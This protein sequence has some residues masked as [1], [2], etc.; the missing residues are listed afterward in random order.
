MAA[1]KILDVFIEWNPNSEED[2]RRE[3][4]RWYGPN[5]ELELVLPEGIPSE[6]I[7]ACKVYYFDPFTGEKT[8]AQGTKTFSHSAGD[9]LPVGD[10]NEISV[11]FTTTANSQAGLSSY[12]DPDGDP[13]YDID[14]GVEGKLF[15]KVVRVAS[16]LEDK[17]DWTI[18][19]TE[20]DYGE[21][22][23]PDFQAA[24]ARYLH[25]EEDEN[26]SFEELYVSTSP[27]PNAVVKGDYEYSFNI[28]DVLDAGTHILTV[29]FT[30]SNQPFE[31]KYNDSISPVTKEISV[32]VNPIPPVIQWDT[33]QKSGAGS[34]GE[35]FISPCEV[36]SEETP[37]ITN[38]QA[39]Y[40]VEALSPVEGSVGQGDPVPGSWV[41]SPPAGTEIYKSTDISAVFTPSDP[42]YSVVSESFSF[43][44][45]EKTETDLT[46]PTLFNGLVVSVDCNVGFGGDTSNCSF[47]VVDDP[48][49]GF[50]TDIPTAGTACY[51]RYKDFF[52]GGILQRWNYSESISG[53]KYNI[54]LSSPSA[55]MD[56]VHIILDAFEGTAY[57]GDTQ[58]EPWTGAQVPY[59]QGLVRN[60]LNPLGYFENYTLGLLSG[61]DPD[62]T[63]LVDDTL[64][65]D[66]GFGTW[67]DSG[68]NPQGFDAIKLL[69]TIE[70]IS[71]G[72]TPHGDKLFFGESQ[73]SLDLSELIEVVPEY[74]RVSGSPNIDLNSL[75]SDVC[76]LTQRDYIWEVTGETNEECDD[77]GEPF[78]DQDNVVLKVKLIDKSSPPDPGVIAQYVE[79]ARE[80]GT[81]VNSSVGKEFQ[82]EPTQKIVLGGPASRYFLATAADLIP[83]FAQTN[84]GAYVLARDFET[85][86]DGAYD[87]DR[88]VT[89]YV[90][91][92]YTSPFSGGGNRSYTATIM[93]LRQARM[94]YD[95]WVSFKFVE[96]VWKNTLGLLDPNSGAYEGFSV[97]ADGNFGGFAAALGFAKPAGPLGG[98]PA[99]VILNNI[100]NV[101][102][103]SA[104]GP[105]ALNRAELAG[106]FERFL[107]YIEV[108]NIET[109]ESSPVWQAVSEC[110]TN[111]YGRKFLV[112]LPEEPG[113]IE[114][115]LKVFKEDIAQVPSWGL[116]DS[117]WVEDAPLSNVKF[118]DSTGRLKPLNVYQLGSYNQGAVG[119]TLNTTAIQGVAYQGPSFQQG[120][121]WI[122]WPGSVDYSP[123]VLA[124][125]EMQV[126]TTDLFHSKDHGFLNMLLYMNE[127]FDGTDLAR[128]NPAFRE[129]LGMTT[130]DSNGKTEINWRPYGFGPAI[131]PPL[132]IGIPQE[133]KRYSWGPWYNS[134]HLNG[135]LDFVFDSQ[136]VPESFGSIDTMAETAQAQAD[137]GIATMEE[138]ENGSIEIA[139]FPEYNIGDRLIAT[140]PYV[141]SI[142]IKIGVGGMT[143][144]YR[145]NTWTPDFGKLQ[146]YNQSR[147]ARIWRNK[148]NAAQ[149]GGG[150]V[151]GAKDSTVKAQEKILDNPVNKSAFN[152]HV[153]IIAGNAGYEP[154]TQSAGEISPIVGSASIVD[155]FIPAENRPNNHQEVT[156]VITESISDVVFTDPAGVGPRYS[157][158]FGMSKEQT[159]VGFSSNRERN[160]HDV[161]PSIQDPDIDEEIVAGEG[162]ENSPGTFNYYRNTQG[163]SADNNGS[164]M[165]TSN[166]LDPYFNYAVFT[167]NDTFNVVGSDG[168]E[169]TNPANL[170]IKAMSDD[171]QIVVHDKN[172]LPP[173]TMNLKTGL[174]LEEYATNASNNYTTDQT[175]DSLSEFRP[176]GL[177]G[178]MVLS[179]WGFDVAN[180]PVPGTVEDIRLFNNNLAYNRNLWKTGPVNLMW[181]KERKIW[182]GGLETLTGIV[183]TDVESPESPMNPTTFN[184]KV[185]R[186]VSDQKG[187]GAL[188]HND[189]PEIIKCYNRDP[190]FSMNAGENSYLTVMRINYEWVPLS[191]GGGVDLVGFETQDPDDICTTDTQVWWLAISRHSNANS[192]TITDPTEFPMQT[193]NNYYDWGGFQPRKPD[194]HLDYCQN[195]GETDGTQVW[196]NHTD[197]IYHGSSKDN[198]ATNP[199]EGMNME[200]WIMKT[201]Y[202]RPGNACMK[203]RAIAAS[204]INVN[205]DPSYTGDFFGIRDSYTNETGDPTDPLDSELDDTLAHYFFFVKDWVGDLSDDDQ[206]NDFP[207]GPELSEYPT[208]GRY[209]Y[210]DSAFPAV[211]VY[212][213]DDMTASDVA[214]AIMDAWRDS[215]F[216]ESFSM[217]QD[218]EVITICQTRDGLTGDQNN[219][220][221]AR[222]ALQPITSTH[223]NPDLENGRPHEGNFSEGE[224]FDATTWLADNSSHIIDWINLSENGTYF[225]NGAP[226]D[227]WVAGGGAWTG[228]TDAPVS[229][230]GTI[231]E[232]GINKEYGYPNSLRKDDWLDMI[233]ILN[234]MSGYLGNHNF[235]IESFT[236]LT[237]A[238]DPDTNLPYLSDCNEVDRRCITLESRPEIEEII[239]RIT[240]YP[241][242][243]TSVPDEISVTPDP[244]RGA[245]EVDPT[246]NAGGYIKI[247]DP[248]EGF[249]GGEYPRRFESDLRGRK[250]VAMRVWDYLPNGPCHDDPDYDGAGVV[251]EDITIKDVV[252]AS[253]Q[254]VITVEGLLPTRASGVNAQIKQGDLT[255]DI[256][257]VDRSTNSVTI[258]LGGQ[259]LPELGA[260]QLCSG[261][262]PECYWMVVYMDMFDTIELVHD[263]IIGT[264]TITTQKKKVDVWNHCDLD[265]D[266]YEGE[267]CVFDDED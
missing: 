250:G 79:D 81:L 114:N 38:S 123:F 239:G 187:D 44:V 80:A 143:T 63:W 100:A 66:W 185:L 23:G 92:L 208:Y 220:G 88:E 251:C 96:F 101:F 84:S 40:P 233:D 132:A 12:L 1:P 264:R 50:I 122:D 16:S 263:I 95:A 238:I 201:C 112:K 14:S 184:L 214:Q 51:F 215:P 41:Y 6:Y 241:C 265:D 235:T 178:P 87:S 166:D 85:V 48:E 74:Y 46:V 91:S 39:E 174:D 231:Y 173:E 69:K 179:G 164:I 118:Y 246:S 64:I 15:I 110:A 57:Y 126:E 165:P 182:S 2:L 204:E 245:W 22:L 107:G 175:V 146:K 140:G 190:K 163:D 147:V 228:P 152:P 149:K 230:T 167:D 144:S 183:V 3:H 131:V 27:A 224:G 218:C 128:A 5:Q 98:L 52:F 45:P 54:T 210:L 153:A 186:K 188:A 222:G 240:Q 47:V 180:N 26:T 255:Y 161:L 171:F 229:G 73:Y 134:N 97:G 252:R 11:T 77:I 35:R 217:T 242:G 197:V 142:S 106:M 141:T 150:S 62:D 129:L 17:V 256:V 70:V 249:F 104:R 90:K 86:A 117:A 53:K 158:N 227:A 176:A 56:G 29:T 145:F 78:V 223:P 139:E 7:D 89:L 93:E 262:E 247:K 32:T 82:N 75:V 267:D 37:Y 76:E 127:T 154:Y 221:L 200:F 102:A 257:D 192:S 254:A 121:E 219:E 33:V 151:S 25:R 259:E 193:D 55:F 202:P 258:D 124:D 109:A 72:G 125:T 108:A 65:D 266:V 136:L 59:Q 9:V 49:N 203:L 10:K 19:Q 8:E 199:G 68:T 237:G 4:G 135:K 83:V 113:G 234:D 212:I 20:W 194:H 181:D 211:P 116:A 94:G 111:F 198:V 130:R 232:G 213:N 195:E 168:E 248:M 30:P 31:E 148:M 160:Q 155:D 137:T 172:G 13:A 61:D 18:P 191:S 120:I 162:D 243:V 207:S 24:Q 261:S 226:N 205:T 67:G 42:N 156:S 60:V 115:N 209:T 34:K 36:V 169:E 216:T 99:P 21:P 119:E 28:G 170:Y 138:V 244:L 225:T 43:L 58:F 253:D 196:R 105:M 206:T 159:W 71:R 157:T 236:D 177:R 189:P 260:A 133:S 103:R